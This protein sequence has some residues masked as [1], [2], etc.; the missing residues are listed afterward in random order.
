VW[1]PVVHVDFVFV[2]LMNVLAVGRSCSHFLES[3]L[4]F[5]PFFLDN[6]LMEGPF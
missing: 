5:R 1:F 4:S 3:I 2:D 6:C